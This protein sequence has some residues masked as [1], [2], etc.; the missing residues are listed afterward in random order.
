M[1]RGLTKHLPE[2]T[3]RMATNIVIVIVVSGALVHNFIDA[4]K[5]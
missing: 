3:A 4:R 5:K 1:S 2:E